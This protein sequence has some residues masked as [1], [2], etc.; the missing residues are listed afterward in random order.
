[1]ISQS[2]LLSAKAR[3]QGI[4]LGVE[5]LSPNLKAPKGK[6]SSRSSCGR[7]KLAWPETGL[8]HLRETPGFCLT[9]KIRIPSPSRALLCTDS[10]LAG[11]TF[12][13][14]SLPPVMGIFFFFSLGL[15]F[16]QELLVAT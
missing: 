1:M 4:G 3:L 12:R 8:L 16:S 9:V 2:D 15:R 5:Y 11:I 7:E 10:F 13:F 6:E 14:D